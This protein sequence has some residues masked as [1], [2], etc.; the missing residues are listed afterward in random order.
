MKFRIQDNFTARAAQ[1]IADRS[2]KAE[3]IVAI[4]VEKDTQQYVPM[5]TGS[6]NTRTR[7]TKNTIIYP[8]PYARYLYYGKVM[9]DAATGK[10]PMHFTDKLGNE[11]IRFRKG[12]K[13]RPTN[14]DLKYT[15]DFH[16][17]AGPR[18]L[19]RSKAQNL[20]KWER[21]AAKAIAM[22]EPSNE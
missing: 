18:W 4:Q 5:L 19:E 16:K 12:A 10:G 1:M 21:V 17:D 2:K 9:V 22:E 11:Y 13:L 20:K 8:G 3:H 6:L 14:K 7:I 15:K